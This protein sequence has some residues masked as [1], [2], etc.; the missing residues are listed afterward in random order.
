MSTFDKLLAERQR[1]LKTLDKIFVVSDVVYISGPMTG[2]ANFNREMF[3]KV[4]RLIA[5]QGATVLSPADLK[6]GPSWEYQMRQCIRYIADS[7]KIVMLPGWENSRGALIEHLV[8]CQILVPRWYLEENLLRASGIATMKLDVS[9]M[10]RF[11]ED[12]LHD[13]TAEDSL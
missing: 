6:Q 10:T 12:R 8:A 2:I 4:K 11:M 9:F 1:T 7:T 3:T 13:N 5:A